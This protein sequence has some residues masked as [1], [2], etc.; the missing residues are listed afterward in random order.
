MIVHLEMSHKI[1][2]LVR[3]IFSTLSFESQSGIGQ[4]DEEEEEEEEEKEDK[5]KPVFPFQNG[6]TILIP[7]LYGPQQPVIYLELMLSAFVT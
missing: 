4:Q 6:F 5:M 1:M 2:V 3:T 7:S